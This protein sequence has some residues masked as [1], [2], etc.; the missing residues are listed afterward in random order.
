MTRGVDHPAPHAH[1][2]PTGQAFFILFAGPL[3]WFAQ[4]CGSVALLGWPCFPTT[5]R[6][7]VPVAHYGWTRTA[8]LI[9]LLLCLGTALASGVSALRAFNAVRDEKEGGKRAL[10]EVGHGRTRF[11]A[12]WGVLLSFSFAIAIAATGVPI[13]MVSQ[14]AG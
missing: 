5:D 9:L 2:L 12:L 10:I 7:S 3:A 14:C 6:F 13:V 11:T 4:L 8:A 1:K